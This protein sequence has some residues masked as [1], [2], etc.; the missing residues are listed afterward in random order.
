MPRRSKRRARL[1]PTTQLLAASSIAGRVARSLGEGAS[2]A[3][4]TTS[5]QELSQ[6]VSNIEWES[7]APWQIT[8][9]N[10]LLKNSKMKWMKP[11]KNSVLFWGWLQARMPSSIGLKQGHQMKGQQEE[12]W[13]KNSFA[14]LSALW[15]Q[16]SKMLFTT[17]SAFFFW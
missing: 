5:L 11:W 1:L 8:S 14:L 9:E 3:A 7:S 13:E 2:S 10:F 17:I 12:T 6:L 15:L 16:S 4:T